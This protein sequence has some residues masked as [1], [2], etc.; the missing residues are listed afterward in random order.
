MRSTKKIAT[1]LLLGIALVGSAACNGGSDGS[2]G[3]AGGTEPPDHP[4]ASIT[5]TFHLATHNGNPLPALVWDDHSAAGFGA[6][7]YAL[8]GSIVLRPDGSYRQTGDSRLV[9]EADAAHPGTAQ[10][11]NSI[12]DG[13][14]SFA[15]LDPGADYGE[16]TF[17]GES[18]GQV[19]CPLTQFSIT[20]PA[21]VP[22]PVGQPDV[23]VTLVY[24]R[25]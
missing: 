13:S 4:A 23:A 3:P 25:D 21:S 11:W 5:G 24:V 19:T 18:G 15:P 7:M 1:R 6:Q 20:C 22:G 16:L 9:I 12:T 2:T 10:V 8:S 17:R 14:Y